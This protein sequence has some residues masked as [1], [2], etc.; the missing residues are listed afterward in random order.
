MGLSRTQ[1]SCR[2]EAWVAPVWWADGWQ[3][4]GNR[5]SSEAGACSPKPPKPQLHAWHYVNPPEF[6]CNLRAGK[7]I[8]LIPI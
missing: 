5:L 7:G 8:E 1:G 2:Q 4:G 6:V 3:S